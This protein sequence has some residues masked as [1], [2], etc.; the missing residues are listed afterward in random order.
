[1]QACQRY[2]FYENGWYFGNISSH[3]VP[4]L[5][6]YMSKLT[7]FDCICLAKNHQLLGLGVFNNTCGHTSIHAISRKW[8]KWG[9]GETYTKALEIRIHY[10]SIISTAGE[11]LVRSSI[12]I[13]WASEIINIQLDS[14]PHP[15]LNAVRVWYGPYFCKS[16]RFG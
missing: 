3:I 5:K 7:N 4:Y 10:I 14:N 12:S 6:I 11:S 16:P 2:S 8:I 1:M 9:L 13:T 15:I